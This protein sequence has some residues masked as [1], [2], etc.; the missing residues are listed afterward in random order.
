MLIGV[1]TLMVFS[2]SLTL[3]ND[4]SDVAR[5]AFSPTHDTDA[6]VSM[7]GISSVPLSGTTRAPAR[8]KTAVAANS[9]MISDENSSGTSAPPPVKSDTL[10]ARASGD[11]LP[12]RFSAAV[13]A[14]SLFRG[15]YSY[16]DRT[17]VPSTS[18]GSRVRSTAVVWPL[19][20]SGSSWCFGSLARA[21]PAAVCSASNFSARSM[22]AFRPS[23]SATFASNAVTSSALIARPSALALS[24]IDFASAITA[25]RFSASPIVFSPSVVQS[26]KARPPLLGLMR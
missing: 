6:P 4:A 16:S 7:R 14:A 8:R 10:S 21:S 17:I 9:G 1:T 26:E 18:P 2:I 22:V 15:P 20:G 25:S 19:A 12:Y 23:A 11:P 24:R 3:P 13:T 5:S